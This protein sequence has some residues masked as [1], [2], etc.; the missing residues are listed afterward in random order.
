[1]TTGVLRLRLPMYKLIDVTSF[2]NTSEFI[3]TRLRHARLRNSNFYKTNTCAFRFGTHL[4][5]TRLAHFVISL[6]HYSSNRAKA[7][8]LGGRDETNHF[9]R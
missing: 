3:M 7:E 8:A 5:S 9:S 4:V 6:M 1:M 2:S